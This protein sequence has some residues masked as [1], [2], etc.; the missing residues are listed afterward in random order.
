M[1]RRT[2]DAFDYVEMYALEAT[3][4]LEAKGI[5]ITPAIMFE[6]ISKAIEEARRQ[7]PRTCYIRDDNQREKEVFAIWGKVKHG[8]MRMKEICDYIN[9]QTDI[10]AMTINRYILRFRRGYNPTKPRYE[11]MLKAS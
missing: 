6:V 2:L 7:A 3:K 5:H 11:D 4:E 10:P 9:R 1:S 8:D